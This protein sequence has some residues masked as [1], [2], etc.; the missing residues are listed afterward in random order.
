VYEEEEEEGMKKKM[1][2]RKMLPQENEDASHRNRVNL[3]V[4]QSD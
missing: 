4:T 3:Q 2:E 1:V